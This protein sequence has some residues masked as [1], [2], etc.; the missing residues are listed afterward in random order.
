MTFSQE[1]LQA[2]DLFDEIAREPGNSVRLPLEPGDLLVVNNYVVLHARSAFE[3][4]PQAQRRRRLLRIWLDARNLRAVPEE[5]D[6]MGQAERHSLP[7][8]PL[9]Q[10]RLPEVVSRSGSQAARARRRDS[11]QPV[12]AQ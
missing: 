5:F 3:D 7:A 2:I 11:S 4:H 12:R 1:E 9:V 8:R 10:L 6:Q